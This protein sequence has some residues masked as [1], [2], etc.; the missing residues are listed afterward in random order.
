M[1]VKLAIRNMTEHSGQPNPAE[2]LQRTLAEHSQQIHTHGSTLQTLLDQ[3]RQ[4][5]QQLEHLA[6]LFQRGCSPESAAP[7]GGAAEH[8]APQQQLLSGDVT[9]PNPEKFS[10]EVGG[11]RGSLLQCTLV[12]NQ[13]PRSFPH[14]EGL[15]PRTL[16][17]MLC[18]ASSALGT[19]KNRPSPFCCQAV[20]LLLNLGGREPGAASP[21]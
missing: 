9:F 1:W 8:L 14:D 19:L 15:V 12:F 10:G 17:P 11:C 3:E 21:P 13:S 6:S 4:T 20:L 5:N 16:N 7:V 18:P 2:A